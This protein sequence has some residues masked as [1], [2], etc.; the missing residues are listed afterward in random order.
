MND[1][2]KRLDEKNRIKWLDDYQKNIYDV[3][4]KLVFE[5]DVFN[6]DNFNL[7]QILGEVND[8]LDI[9]NSD[10]SD[11]DREELLNDLFIY[12][13]ELSLICDR[14]IVNGYVKKLK[15]NK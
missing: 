2:I 4:S 10:I 5:L 14:N 12:I 6:P 7:K 1:Y 8:I 9:I 11:Q 3:A 15:I 13:D